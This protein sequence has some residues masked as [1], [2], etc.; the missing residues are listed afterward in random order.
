VEVDAYLKIGGEAP[1]DEAEGQNARDT[2]DVS[3]TPTE[4][5]ISS[6]STKRSVDD[7]KG[8]TRVIHRGPTKI[9]PVLAELKTSR[10]LEIKQAL[11]QLW[12]GRIPLL[13]HGEQ[14]YGLFEDIKYIN[15]EARFKQ[16]EEENQTA[17]QQMV[18]LILKL[19]ELVLEH[20]P[21]VVVC[22]A[23]V[24]PPQLDVY[25]STSDK[26]VLPEELLERYWPEPA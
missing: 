26:G 7:G 6:P 17:L 13:L 19:R 16:W 22:D 21:C 1:S 12:F 14:Y 20:G 3:S 9:Y 2:D 11:P 24:R 8:L 15:S 5:N 4:A 18:S 10:H 25:K 23:M